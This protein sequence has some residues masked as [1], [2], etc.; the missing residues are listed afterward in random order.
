[1]Y[2]NVLRL[3]NIIVRSFRA[4]GQV[5]RVASLLGSQAFKGIINEVEQVRLL[6]RADIV[7]ANMRVLSKEFLAQLEEFS[8][9]SLIMVLDALADI[10]VKPDFI[11]EFSAKGF[12][13]SLLPIDGG[14]TL[15]AKRGYGIDFFRRT[16]EVYR[17]SFIYGP[18]PID[19][20][21]ALTLYI[22]AK[23]SLA[24]RKGVLVEIGS[25]RGFSTLWLAHA[26]RE[27]NAH[28]ISID[29]KCDRV[30]YVLKIL[31]DLNLN[32]YTDMLCTDATT[33][34]RGRQD[35]VFAF[36]DGRKDEYHRYLEVLEP[37]LL[38]GALILA[39][40]TISDAHIVKPYLEK[41]Y[42]KPYESITIATDPKGLTISV[43]TA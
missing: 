39:H 21:T 7:L 13:K 42:T 38:P 28:V 12:A 23:F 3:L 37:Y 18:C 30:N 33:Y 5:L 22:L 6:G 15:F 2:S 40:N 4:G 10:S 14:I 34:N 26:S 32:K 16:V 8:S 29:N 19:Y 11:K 1:M 41:V 43:Y 36:I 31:E 17:E 9:S 27:T 20:N 25:G 24:R 35:I